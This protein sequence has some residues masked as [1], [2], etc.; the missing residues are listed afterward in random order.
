[1]QGNIKRRSDIMHIWILFVILVMSVSFIDTFT[2]NY[3]QYGI[4]L[5]KSVV[6]LLITAFSIINPQNHFIETMAL[7]IWFFIIIT[8]GHNLAIYK[9]RNQ[10]GY[11]QN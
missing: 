1:M 3:K 5:K 7:A 6:L 10:A 8:I 9:K 11:Q 4:C 2:Q